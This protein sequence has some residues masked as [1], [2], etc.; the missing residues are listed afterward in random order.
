VRLR[1]LRCRIWG[2]WWMLHEFEHMCVIDHCMRCRE[3]R[4]LHRTGPWPH[5]CG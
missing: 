3:T 5:T 1:G 2:H 4:V